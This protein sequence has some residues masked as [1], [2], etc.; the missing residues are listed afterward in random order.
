MEWLPSV[1]LCVPSVVMMTVELGVVAASGQTITWLVFG[2]TPV[3]TTWVLQSLPPATRTSLTLS[4]GS[5]STSQGLAGRQLRL[6]GADG[7]GDETLAVA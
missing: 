6:A 1:N 2:L 3:E 5:S 7:A 4:A